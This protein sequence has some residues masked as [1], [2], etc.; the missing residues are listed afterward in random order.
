MLISVSSTDF[1]YIGKTTNLIERLRIHNSVYRSSSTEPAHI[2]PYALFAYICGFNED[3][4]LMYYIENKWKE[5]REQMIGQGIMEPR[6][7]AR[8]VNDVTNLDYS[9]FGS[10]V[11]NELRLVLLFI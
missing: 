3:N 11:D 1:V 4:H 2:L 6:A 7:W 8:G 5:K 9:N 10:S